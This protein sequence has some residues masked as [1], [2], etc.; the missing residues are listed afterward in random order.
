[1]LTNKVSCASAFW[2]MRCTLQ[3][4]LAHTKLWSGRSFWGLLKYFSFPLFL[5]K[6]SL[7]CP[8]PPHHLLP[9]GMW[10]MKRP[11]CQFLH[12][13][14]LWLCESTRERKWLT[15]VV[16]LAHTQTGARSDNR[17]PVMYESQLCGPKG[18]GGKAVPRTIRKHAL[19]ILLLNF[20]WGA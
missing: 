11:L 4:S 16:C 20:Q 13:I 18:T 7:W 12:T 15:G 14:Q 2:N 5:S 3:R 9:S 10:V 17:T 8:S 19:F 1:M 6:P